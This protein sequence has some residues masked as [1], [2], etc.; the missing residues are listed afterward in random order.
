MTSVHFTF[1]EAVSEQVQD[2]VGETLRSEGV[3]RVGRISPD[4]KRPSLR[5][6]WY[7]EVADDKAA[8]LAA[9]LSSLGEIE[10][11]ELPAERKLLD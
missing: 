1:K 7:A 3:E 2:D 10:L 6:M 9:K 11:A 5:R 4:A 8:A